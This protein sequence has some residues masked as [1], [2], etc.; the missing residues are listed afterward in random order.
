MRI[1]LGVNETKKNKRYD[2]SERV[3]ERRH[4]GVGG[5]KAGEGRYDEQKGERYE[6]L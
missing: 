2:V 1:R 5:G 4:R 3:G 6:R